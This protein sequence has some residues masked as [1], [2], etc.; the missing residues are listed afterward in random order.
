MSNETKP[1]AVEIWPDKLPPSVVVSYSPGDWETFIYGVSGHLTMDALADIQSQITGEDNESLFDRGPG[2]YL[3]GASH[4]KGQYGP[5]GQCEFAPGWELWVEDF[6]P[7][8]AIPEVA[9]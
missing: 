1:G 5:E 2:D 7:T 8:P 6:R 9:V 4:F 3:L